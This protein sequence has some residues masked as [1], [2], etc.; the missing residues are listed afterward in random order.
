ML[1]DM[2]INNFL[3][4]TVSCN[5]LQSLLRLCRSS[6]KAVLVLISSWVAFCWNILKVQYW[7]QFEQEILFTWYKQLGKAFP[8]QT[9]SC[10]RKLPMHV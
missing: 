8:E 7:Q 10:F 5:S 3:N 2:L 9:I 4:N 6:L 1:L